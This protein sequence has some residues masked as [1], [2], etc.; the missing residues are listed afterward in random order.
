VQL[1][2][3][4]PGAVSTPWHVKQIVNSLDGKREM[5]VPFNKC[6]VTPRIR[7]DRELYTPAKR[8]GTH[9]V[10]LSSTMQ[11]LWA[12]VLPLNLPC[13]MPGIAKMVTFVSVQTS[14]RPS[15]R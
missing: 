4:M 11:K 3:G 2:V 13:G 1:F 9:Q 12:L 8:E 5:P 6:Q 10:D 15:R 14:G 7:D